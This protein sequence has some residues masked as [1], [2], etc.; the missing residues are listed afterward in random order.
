MRL[1]VRT[2]LAYLDDVLEPADADELGKKIEESEFARGLVHRIRA[3]IGKIRLGAPDV[4]DTSQGGNPNEVAEFL[5]NTLDPDIVPEFER[6]CLDFDERLAETAACHQILTL[7]LGEPARLSPTMRGR[8]CDLNRAATQPVTE[9]ETESPLEEIP[10]SSAVLRRIDTPETDSRFRHAPVETPTTLPVDS[11]PTSSLP[12]SSMAADSMPAESMPAESMPAESMPAESMDDSRVPEYLRD[13]PSRRRWPLVMTMILAFLVTSGAL[14]WM[15]PLDS[16][17]PLAG[18]FLTVG[19]KTNELASAADGDGPENSWTDPSDAAATP[20]TELENGEFRTVEIP[21]GTKT[22]IAMLEPSDPS[23]PREMPTTERPIEDDQLPL[24]AGRDSEFPLTEVDPDPGAAPN[25]PLPAEIVE[26]LGTDPFESPTDPPPVRDQQ[27]AVVER[28]GEPGSIEPADGVDTLEGSQ[29]PL[30]ELPD[31]DPSRI[32]EGFVRDNGL[33]NDPIPVVPKPGENELANRPIGDRPSDAVLVAANPPPVEIIDPEPQFNGTPRNDIPESTSADTTDGVEGV[34]RPSLRRDRA[35][36]GRYTSEREVLA[37]WRPE[38]KKWIRMPARGFVGSGSL[39]R[40]APSFRPNISL[41]S[42]V[43]VTIASGSELLF[44]ARPDDGTPIL[45]LRHGG[46]VL[47]DSSPDE[48]AVDIVVGSRE[49]TITLGGND[50]QLA[51]NVTRECELGSDPESAD[52]HT[53]SRFWC[54]TGKMQLAERGEPTATVQAGEEVTCFDDFP[55]R[56]RETVE[57]PPL[58]LDQPEGEK[59]R[60]SAVA[61]AKQLVENRS[62]VL[63]LIEANENRRMVDVRSLAARALTM[64]DQFDAIVDAFGDSSQKW[65]WSRHFD[66][67]VERINAS[68]ESAGSLRRALEKRYSPVDAGQ[69][70]RMFWGYSADDLAPASGKAA[71]LVSFLDDERLEYRVLSFVN[72]SQITENTMGYRAYYPKTRRAKPLSRWQELLQNNGILH[73]TPPN[74]LG[75]TFLEIP[76]AL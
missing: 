54:L 50:T 56:Y 73:K 16:E 26:P 59:E 4:S 72:L 7:V 3:S 40:V 2:L 11:L 24:G 51:I 48:V 41:N 75:D 32:N 31:T 29:T 76:D 47:A 65:E 30:D 18:V 14:L 9:V 66:Y 74:D 21:N 6:S 68:S 5:D 39:V 44:D 64:F 62:L 25:K 19:S 69:L 46:L 23:L 70:Y 38:G 42:G 35:D 63:S 52:R 34:A 28:T 49:I 10:T 57:T 33:A 60:A 37:I 43:Q 53:L 12:T 27:V 61:L 13:E 71:E 55:P 20:M 36:L 22:V 8:V 45:K 17:H 58:V 1:T 15:G 67:V